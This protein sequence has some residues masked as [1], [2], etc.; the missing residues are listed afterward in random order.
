[1]YTCP[2]IGQ[3]EDDKML[4]GLALQLTRMRYYYTVDDNVGAV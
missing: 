3:L 2:A 1:M 4:I